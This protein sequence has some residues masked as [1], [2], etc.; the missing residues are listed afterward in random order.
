MTLHDCIPQLYNLASVT[1]SSGWPA[2][3]SAGKPEHSGPG[4]YPAPRQ[5]PSGQDYRSRL[6]MQCCIFVNVTVYEINPAFSSV[7]GWIR[8][9]VNPPSCFTFL[10]FNYPSDVRFLYWCLLSCKTDSEKWAERRCFSW[11]GRNGWK[12]VRSAHTV[13]CSSYTRTAGKNQ[14]SLARNSI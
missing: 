3:R 9:D 14:R 11:M 8:P 2:C 13:H 7:V 10:T 4:V 1:V 5:Y 6:H 12:N